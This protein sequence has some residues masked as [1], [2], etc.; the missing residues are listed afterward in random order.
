M[1]K[2]FMRPDLDL[3]FAEIHEAAHQKQLIELLRQRFGH[4]ADFSLL[5]HDSLTNIE[6]MEAAL[7]DVSHSGFAFA[8][9]L[10]VVAIRQQFAATP[11]TSLTE[12][13]FA[14]N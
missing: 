10:V 3:T 13:S 1:Q 4:V 2:F 5:R 12:P 11:Q 9:S 6:H 8:L 7:S 14:A